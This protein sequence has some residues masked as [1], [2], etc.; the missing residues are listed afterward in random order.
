M[1]QLVTLILELLPR[2][3]KE[4]REQ[5]KEKKVISNRGGGRKGKIERKRK[6][7]LLGKMGK[8]GP[9]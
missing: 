8:F 6:R 2:V 4:I 5:Q 9:Q 7:Q 1:R 3:L